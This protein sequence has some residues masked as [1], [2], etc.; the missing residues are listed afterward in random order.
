MLSNDSNSLFL[1]LFDLM[2]LT[3]KGKA[4]PFSCWTAMDKLKFTDGSEVNVMVC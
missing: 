4:L 2:D 3:R 1:T